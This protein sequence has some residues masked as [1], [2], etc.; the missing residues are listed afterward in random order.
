ML[1]KRVKSRYPSPLTQLRTFS[2]Q[3]K[4]NIDPKEHFNCFHYPLGRKKIEIDEKLAQAM[5][6]K[7]M[8]ALKV[9]IFLFL[10]F[11]SHDRD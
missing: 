4:N 6:V 7:A 9:S 3:L 11:N 8:D 1:L 2:M 5:K 10:F